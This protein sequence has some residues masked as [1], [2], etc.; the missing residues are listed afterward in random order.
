V[1]ASV[2]SMRGYASKVG[3]DFHEVKW[4][5][6]ESSKPYNGKPVWAFIDFLKRFREQ[7]YYKELLVLDSDVLILSSCPDLFERKGGL[8]C[9]LDQVWP[10][11]DNRYREWVAKHFPDSTENESVVDEP[12]FNAGVLLF[13]LD[14]LRTINFDPPYPDEMGYD[15][16][17][18]NMRVA[19]A[20]ID[21]TW[22]GEEYNQ[23]NV[24]DRQ[25]TITNNHILHFVG[26]G[27]ER[28][29]EYAD[30]LRLG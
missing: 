2:S 24:D 12:Y 5:P 22:V 11:K 9:A 17:F 1:R 29:M 19:E 26:G 21:V 30:F 10:K 7:D 14:A 15:Q 18:L 20:G 8:V 3:A 27:K 6:D 13:R 25:K 16:D 28:L 4:F 23:R